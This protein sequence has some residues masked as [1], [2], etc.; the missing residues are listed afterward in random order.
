MPLDSP[1]FCW[2]FETIHDPLSSLPYTLGPNV[3][4][5]AVLGASRETTFPFNV[6]CV[7]TMGRLGMPLASPIF[8]WFFQ[9]IHDPLSSLPYPLGPNVN[10]WAVL[11]GSRE[12]TLSLNV[13]CV[14]QVG[15]LG[16]PLASLIFGW[17]FE[18][19]HDPLSSLPDNLGP[20]VNRW[21]TLKTFTEPTFPVLVT[22]VGQVGRL[23]MPL[24]FPIFCRFFET[25]HDPL[26]EIPYPL[27][28]N[29]NRW[30][31]LGAS[32]EPTF[33]HN[34]TCVGQVGR[35][36]MPLASFIFCWF[37]ETIQDPLS[38]LPYTLGPNVNRWAA[39]KTST[40]PTF[41]V[42][43]TCVGQ[44]GRLGIPLSFPI[45]C[46]FFKTIHDP[47]SEI[48]CPLGP[49]VNSWAV[50]GA[51]REPTFP[52]NVTC[53]GTMGRLGMPLASPIFCWFFE[54]IHD[55]LS[56]LPYPLRPNVNSWA[57]LG[58]SREPTFSLNVTCV[59]QVGRL[60]MPL[61]FLIFCWFFETI[62]DPL[63][64]LPYTLG[65]NV[66]R[67]AALK[68]STEPTFPVFVTCV[69][70]VGRLGMPLAFP[71]FCRFF[72]T[73]HDPLSE[74]PCPLG[75]NVNSWAVLVAS[76]ET[77]FPFNVT[78][79]G[80][81]GRLG[82]PLASFIFCWL[83]ETI[84]DPL[85]SLPYNLG[86]N[87]NRWAALKTSTEPTFPVF[88]TC[89]GQVG[90]LGMPLAFPIFCRF[91]K[92]IH[93]PL[94][95]IP[96]PLGPNVNS[97][98]VLGASR[99]PTFPFNVTCVSTMGRLGIPLAS[100]IFCW[101]FET[102]HDPLSSLPY[103][104]GPNVNR[105]AALKTSTETTFPV[106]VTCVGQVGR[107]GMPLAF[108]IFCRFFKT[109]HDPLSEIPCPLGPNV[110]S[111]AVLGASREPTFPFNVT[112]VG[113][114]GRLGIPFAS[115][116]I[117]WFFE[118]IH[119]PL[120]SLPYPLGPNMNRWA[121]LGASREP[122]LS[123]NVTCVGQ[124]GRLGMPLASLIFCWFFE[125]IHDPLSE[126]PCPLGPNVNRWDAL[127]TST[128]PTFPVLVTCV[129]QVGRLGMPLAFPIC[130][131][132]FETI[133]DPVSEIPCPLGPNV[134]SWAV[135]GA[136][137]EPTFPFNVTCVGTMGRLGIPLASPIFCW[138]F[139]T[140]HDRLN[141]LPYP[142]GPNVNRWAVLGAS[143]EPTLSLNVTCVGQVG[144]LGMPLA[145][146]IF[147]WFFETIH[148]PLSEI[149]CPL[150]AKC[151]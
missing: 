76:R 91:F 151:E 112:C 132:F 144:R 4:S 93:D 54:T 124:V 119:D 127:K 29:V 21:A 129:G 18:T 77:T 70:Q 72:K 2:F 48:P 137:R 85:S 56:S 78:C 111:W 22:C 27:G 97:W 50:P 3:N 109:I 42:F 57:V 123:L 36:G 75:P 74:I 148:D 131:R 39:L 8:C 98:A 88:V 86:P 108:P 37:F 118:T 143:R 105:W 147:C 142:L 95:E 43:V 41:P 1:I 136:S 84:H 126:I 145:S 62:H 61:A 45:F 20:N 104:L 28:P 6:T 32:R 106:F 13:T 23:G 15:R 116:I 49:N 149:P 135:L 68:T 146:L 138:F 90:R 117:C 53:V 31:V 73:I 17:F 83:F 92:T 14:G 59:G 134:N 5:W 47:L 140:I 67:W 122:T 19:I 87:V 141:S 55:P 102:I 34:V 79:V 16:M 130:C 115:P 24:A 96:C 101:F 113:T 107:L 103:P 12:P 9:T 65:P 58:A 99:E 10:R 46:R 110:N 81:M 71:I 26:S 25:I 150:R 30:A 94:S 38:S 89:V 100:P 33:C 60:G 44:V 51:A 114:M 63:S 35:L 120:S 52:F 125:T 40:E 64:L 82:M 128:E 133:H 7:G 80:T 121:V 66:N 69:G 11:G 139:E